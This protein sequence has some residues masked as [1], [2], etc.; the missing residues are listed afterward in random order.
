LDHSEP[1]PRNSFDPLGAAEHGSLDLQFPIH[2]KEIGLFSFQTPHLITNVYE[3]QTTPDRHKDKGAY[4]QKQHQTR[5][6][7]SKA[8]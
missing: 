8:R 1:L 6:Q 2:M 4:D 5:K 3:G 7:F